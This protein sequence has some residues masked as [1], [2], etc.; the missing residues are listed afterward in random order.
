MSSMKQVLVLGGTGFVGR[1]VCECLAELAP[2]TR[3]RVPTRRAAHGNSVRFLP[4]VDLLSANVHDEA[5]LR[6]LVA[7]CD[8]VVNLVAIL[9]GSAAAFEQVH[10]AL[11]R[12][13]A[14]ACQAA[15]VRRLVHVSALGVGPGAPSNYLRSKTAGEAVLQ[16]AKLDLTVLR[17]SVIFGVDDHFLNLFAQLQAVA[18]V[19]PLAGSDAR[20]QPV[21]VQDVAQGIVAALMQP[22][23]IGQVIECAGPDVLTLSELVRLSGRWAGVERAQIPLPAAVGRLQAAMME[24]LPGEPLM[25]RDNVDSMRVPNVASGKLPGLQSLG[26]TPAAVA[27]VAPGYLGRHQG[28]AR[29]DV[30]RRL[31]RRD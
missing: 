23:S 7:G 29:L 3:V 14:Q 28:V 27:A 25:S 8:A 5:A 18:P 20:F 11:P 22:Q 2:A 13:L 15:G 9:H 12:K 10:V 4:N 31:A 30:W 1:A 24:W 21:W 17:P 16:E 26:I 6:R 19:F